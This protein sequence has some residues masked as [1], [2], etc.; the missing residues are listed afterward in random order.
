MRNLRLVFKR[1]MEENYLAKC[2]VLSRSFINA[3]LPLRVDLSF[4]DMGKFFAACD[5]NLEQQ[6]FFR[7]LAVTG[8]RSG[9]LAKRV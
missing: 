5:H 3:E 1:A 4:D 2:P 8:M 9:E 7:I 6:V